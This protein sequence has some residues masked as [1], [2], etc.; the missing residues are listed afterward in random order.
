MFKGF[1]FICSFLVLG[2]CAAYNPE[3]E[4]DLVTPARLQDVSLTESTYPDD[5]V[6]RGKYLAGLLA[7]GTCHTDGALVGEP[8]ADR[9]YGGSGVGIA[10]TSPFDGKNPGILYPANITA[11][12]ETGIGRWSDTE[13]VRAIRTGI[14]NHGR[15][16]ISVMP[17]PGYTQIVDE[18]AFAIVAFLRSLKTVR[19]SV[20]KNVMP[21]EN[22]S[23]AFVHF[24]IYRSKK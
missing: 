7:C 22:H 18:D 6:Q 23:A 1:F 3:S 21:G 19:H 14:N 11:D 12:L 13:V 9:V 10:Y 8:D 20:P 4:Y 17:W 16:Q 5:M 2:A 15:R 24:G